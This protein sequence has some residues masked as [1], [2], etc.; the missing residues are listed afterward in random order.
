MNIYYFANQVYQLSYAWPL[1]SRIGGE[2]IVRKYRTLIKFKRF[3]RGSVSTGSRAFLGTPIVKRRKLRYVSDL[4]G[5]I[6]SQSNAK[7][8]N[9]REKSRSIFVGHGT[10]DKKYG[11]R[12]R[13]L[14]N[15]QYVFV[16]GPKHMEKF[17]D[18]NLSFPEKSLVKIGNLRFDDY[19]NGKLDRDAIMNRMGIPE[20]DRGRKTV[21]Y[22]P[23]WEWG[24]GTLDRYAKYF[25]KEITREHNLVI[26]P[27]HFDS[28]KVPKLKLWAKL[29]GMKRVYFSNSNRIATSDT[30]HDF[31]VSDILISDTSSVLYEYLV[32]EKPIVIA[33]TDFSDLHSMPDTMN[34]MKIADNYDDS[35]NILDVVNRSLSKES[36]TARYAEMLHNCFY[37]NDGNSVERAVSFINDVSGELK[38]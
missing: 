24:N 15:Y 4:T 34:V 6:L 22:A 16:S 17:K 7:V 30:M 29:N 11:G 27:H 23:T 35:S 12:A 14:L 13:T 28:H 9:D 10:G 21:L 20:A 8:R 1:Y 2:F 19:I 38:Q 33:N 36:N 25:A 37:F 31:L 18:S 32:T 26:R 5:V 3:L